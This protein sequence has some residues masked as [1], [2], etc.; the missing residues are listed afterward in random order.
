MEKSYTQRLAD[1][2]AELTYDQIPKPALEQA[3]KMTLHTVGAAIASMGLENAKKPIALA[4]EVG[5]TPTSTVWGCHSGTKISAQEAAFANGTLADLL[6]WEDCSWTGHGSAGLIPAAMA[7]GEQEHCS[8]REYLTAVVAGF[9]G[10]HRISMA[11]QPSLSYL[12][13]GIGWGLV[14]WQIFAASLP[15]GKLKH[16]DGDQFNQLFGASQY[17]T[18]VPTNRHSEGNRKSDVYHYCHGFCA[19]NGIAAANLTEKGFSNLDNCFEGNKSAYWQFVSDR[20][21]L[22]WLTRKLGE[23]WYINSTYLKHWPANMWIQTSLEAL[24]LLFQTHPFALDEVDKIRVSPTMEMIC[25]NYAASSRTCLDAQFSTGYCLT[26][27]LLDPT[28][29][30]G[31]HWFTGEKLNDPRLIAFADT[32]YEYFGPVKTPLG[33]FEEFRTGSF[34]EATVE[35]HLKDG[36]VYSETTRYPKGHPRNNFTMEEECRHF[37]DCCRPYMPEEQIR[38]IQEKVK[39]L[40]DLN[41]IGELARLCAVYK[42]G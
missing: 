40:E 2:L 8:G 25:G 37:Y 19:R 29:T 10:Y 35:V 39:H 42:E 18:V 14:S 16:F 27:Y 12:S 21:D 15:A 41:D 33:C 36:T 38:A 32:K 24:D 11:V 1:F 9:E 26:S 13:S 7:L 31:A 30:K 34:P 4:M 17:C 6:D 28:H 23:E 3:K 20:V 22:E 5:G